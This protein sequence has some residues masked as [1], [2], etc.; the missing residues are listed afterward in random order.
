MFEHASAGSLVLLC[1]SSLKDAALFLRDNERLFVHATCEVVIMGGVEPFE[2]SAPGSGA[3][4]GGRRRS[5]VA[6][7]AALGTAWR[8]GETFLKPD[9]A[10]NNQ[11]DQHSA[12][13]FYSRCQ[14]LGVPLVIVTRHAA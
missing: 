14:Q 2:P 13:F 10:H 3:T 12:A 4:R 5:F 8:A 1:I 11:F 6:T 9:S 7:D